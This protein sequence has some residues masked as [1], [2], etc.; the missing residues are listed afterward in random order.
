M[1]HKITHKITMSG[2]LALCGLALQHV[3]EL[4][5]NFTGDHLIAGALMLVSTIPFVAIPVHLATRPVTSKWG[6]R[7]TERS[8]GAR[9]SSELNIVLPVGA[10]QCLPTC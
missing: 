5:S 4:G 6:E 2:L 3:A 10:T 1:K 7:G 8:G 9:C